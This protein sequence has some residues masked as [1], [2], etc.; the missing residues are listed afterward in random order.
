MLTP[1][2]ASDD[3]K[4]YMTVRRRMLDFEGALNDKYISDQKINEANDNAISILDKLYFLFDIISIFR[5]IVSG[6]A[7][8]MIL[9]LTSKASD[10]DFLTCFC[11]ITKIADFFFYIS[12]F[13][14]FFIDVTF[15]CI[16]FFARSASISRFLMM[17]TSVVLGISLFLS[18]YSLPMTMFVIN[19]EK[20]VTKWYSLPAS[21][22]YFSSR[23]KNIYKPLYI[24]RMVILVITAPVSV[25]AVMF[26]KRKVFDELYFLHFSRRI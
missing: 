16:I 4:E 20:N 17:F 18:T 19:I 26:T 14:V 3:D 13:I 11:Q 6:M 21:V 7:F 15:L 12:N 22:F 25:V 1:R 2:V 10:V 23:I 24:I 5:I 9:M 8:G